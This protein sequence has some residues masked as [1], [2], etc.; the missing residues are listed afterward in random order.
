MS[1]SQNK[2]AKKADNLIRIVIPAH[3]AANTLPI[4]IEAILR[5]GF[6]GE[7]V[8]VDDGEN[9]DIYEL[10]SSYPVQILKAE[11]S[12]GAAQARNRGASGFAGDILVFVDADVEIEKNTLTSLTAPIRQ[13][14]CEATVG[15]Y[16]CNTSGMNFAQKYKQLYVS[17]IYSR[18]VGYIRNEFW[19]ALGAMRADL[20]NELGGFRSRF[21]PGEDTELGHRLTKKGG[22]IVA[23]PK[24]CG[25]HWKPYTYRS[26]FVNDLR[27]G[28]RIT[29]LYFE[30]GESLSTYRHSSLRDI[31]SVALAYCIVAS[32]LV[33]WE[34]PFSIAV[35][36]CA[37][38]IYLYTRKDLLI[39]YKNLG[40]FFL[41]KAAFSAFLLDL[42]RGLSVLIGISKGIFQRIKD[43]HPNRR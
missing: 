17:F 35:L 20:F 41:I 40:L 32:F 37:F 36:P 25:K 6:K 1:G 42:I 7:I 4:C 33:S 28:I 26:M 29:S 15:N 21:E 18:R 43:R 23:L 8:V 31:L 38:V 12:I 22:R 34:A 13:G 3:R 16:S 14:L 10:L 19:T 2:P 24:A 5:C 11:G 30:T 27:K 9:G 39:V